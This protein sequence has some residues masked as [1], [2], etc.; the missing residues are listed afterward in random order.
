MNVF[1]LDSKA[2]PDLTCAQYDVKISPTDTPPKLNRQI[3]KHLQDDLKAFGA[4]GVVYDGRA[5]A[6]ASEFYEFQLF[7]RIRTDDVLASKLPQESGSWK[8]NLPEDDGR[9]SAKG[10]AFEITI[11][12]TRSINL[13][14]LAA[15]VKGSGG[16]GKDSVDDSE[17][18]GA[19]QARKSSFLLFLLWSF[20]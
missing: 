9:V 13:G 16:R 8:V 2:L 12:Y 18:Q 11:T 1:Q 5:L 3:W 20:Y 10:R 17:I 15:F 6:F 4:I 19:C 14:R 7:D